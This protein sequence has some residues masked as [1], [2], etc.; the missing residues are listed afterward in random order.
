MLSTMLRA[1][2]LR[3]G[4]PGG[5]RTPDPRL[6]RPLLYPAE[7]RAR[8][9]KPSSVGP[10][11][12]SGVPAITVMSKSRGGRIRTG[13]LLRPRQA[14]YQAA[15]RPGTPRR[16]RAPPNR[17]GERESLADRRTPVKGAATQIGRA[18][19]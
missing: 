18:H 15:L 8:I 3:T 17:L 12:P 6:R 4:A 1:T 14:R 5:S 10:P 13:D 11:L 2:L 9:P 19:V 16:R 7:L